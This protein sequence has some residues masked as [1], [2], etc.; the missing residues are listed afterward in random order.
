[1]ISAWR[2]AICLGA[3]SPTITDRVRD[4]ADDKNDGDCL[5][6]RGAIKAKSS[7]KGRQ[8]VGDI[9]AAI[10]TRQNPDQR[11]TDLYR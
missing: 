1:V 11:D 7:K 3:S 6:V 5:A 10:G 2:S 8:A 4:D 9:R